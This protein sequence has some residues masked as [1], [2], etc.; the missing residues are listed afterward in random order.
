MRSAESLGVVDACVTRDADGEFLVVCFS[1]WLLA[2]LP[3]SVISP[4]DPL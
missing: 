1:C 3:R 4:L 2:S